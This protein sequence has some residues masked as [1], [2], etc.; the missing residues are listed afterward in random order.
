MSDPTTVLDDGAELRALLRRVYPLLLERAYADAGAALGVDLAFDVSN[1]R[2]QD[3]LE[4]LAT[5]V[6]GVVETTKEQIRALVAQAAAEGWAPDELAAAIREAGVTDSATRS[7]L[8]AVTETA[9]AY[10]QGSLLAYA[11]SG[12]VDRKQWLLGPEPCAVCAPLGDQVVGLDALFAGAF[13]APPAH[14]R[15]TCAVAPVLSGA[16]D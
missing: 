4:Q 15:C 10:S 14:P 7:R 3:T 8:I 16:E 5:R 9:T 12:V 2:V 6:T 1:P 13:A 11:D